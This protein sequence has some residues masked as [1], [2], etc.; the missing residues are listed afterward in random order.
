MESKETKSAE[1]G[2]RKKGRKEGRRRE[3]KKWGKR[4]KWESGARN[5]EE[6]E[7]LGEGKGRRVESKEN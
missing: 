7:K 4:A 5:K 6:K 2:K 3:R 1:D